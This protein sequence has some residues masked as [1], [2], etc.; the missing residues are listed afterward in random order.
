MSGLMLLVVTGH[1]IDEGP[2]IA[3]FSKT[4]GLHRGDLLVLGAWLVGMVALATAVL[5]PARPRE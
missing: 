1:Y 4:H 3:T 2:V 5:A